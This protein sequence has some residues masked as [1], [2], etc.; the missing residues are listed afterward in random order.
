MN[1]ICRR[2]SRPA[3]MLAVLCGAIGCSRPAHEQH[4]AAPTVVTAPGI[5]SGSASAAP[6]AS[7]RPAP[8]ARHV[9]ATGG[10]MV[11][12]PAGTLIIRWAQE[13]EDPRV[14]VEAFQ[15]DET[16]V[17]VAAFREC[18]GAHSCSPQDGQNETW[19]TESDKKKLKELCN[20]GKP[21]RDKH[22]MNC[23][24]WAHANAF[25]KWA[26]KRLPTE[27]EWEY[28][29]R[30]PESTK[31]PWSSEKPTPAMLATMVNGC[32]PECAPLRKQLASD[33]F[34]FK[35]NLP[36]GDAWPATAPV[37]SFPSGA[38]AFGALDMAG[39]VEEWTASTGFDDGNGLRGKRS[40]RFRL[41][42][43]SSWMDTWIDAF[44][45]AGRKQFFT[46]GRAAWIGFRCA[47]GGSRVG[48]DK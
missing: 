20:W 10:A 36:I 11:E 24:D 8:V 5:P 32:G 17:T 12:I 25:C 38:S 42:R 48:G 9:D 44:E 14:K 30:G 2:A 27:E 18:V 22:P 47:R 23:V 6:S 34:Y 37:G 33:Y 43:G 13:G 3:A 4:D 26:G 39:N 28:A 15:I 29:A 46:A 40:N 45:L 31:F 1:P 21:D 19:S 41:V 16:E 35:E 7:N